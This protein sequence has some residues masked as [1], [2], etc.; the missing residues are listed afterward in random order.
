MRLSVATVIPRRLFVYI[1]K[2]ITRSRITLVGHKRVRYHFGVMDVEQRN[3]LAN[4]ISH[5]ASECDSVVTAFESNWPDAL[6]QAVEVLARARAEIERLSPMNSSYFSQLTAALEVCSPPW[7]K[8]AL[9]C[10]SAVL[11]ALERDLREG[12]LIRFVELV[13]AE[14][15][16]DYLK[17]ASYL[18]HEHYKDP[19]AVVAGSTLEVHLRNLCRKAGLPTEVKGNP[20]G[21]TS[22]NST[23]AAAKIYGSVEEANV[24]AWIR[25][26][27]KAAHGKYAEYTNQHVKGMIDGMRDFI[28]RNPA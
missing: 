13:H 18:L 12:K 20:K 17:M 26:R 5:L 10:A 9:Q 25:L 14:V 11:R 15:F 1:T 28:S 22:L 7:G 16:S 4:L 21:A 24:T 19:A 6:K 3:S 23:L 8:N 2:P 27:N